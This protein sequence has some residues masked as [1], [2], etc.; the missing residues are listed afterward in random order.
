M[1]GSF[2]EHPDSY[3]NPRAQMTLHLTLKHDVFTSRE[4]KFKWPWVIHIQLLLHVLNNTLTLSEGMT[5]LAVS[6]SFDPG[7]LT[8]NT[9][10][11]PPQQLK[12]RFSEP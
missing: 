9:S 12:R 10:F 6:F 8:M 1:L 2:L 5:K 11:I 4:G 7:C 3:S